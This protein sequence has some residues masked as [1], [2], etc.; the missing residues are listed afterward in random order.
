[1]Y[2]GSLVEVVN[3]SILFKIHFIQILGSLCR[4]VPFVVYVKHLQYV[5]YTC[6]VIFV[7]NFLN[8]IVLQFWCLHL[9]VFFSCIVVIRTKCRDIFEF[10]V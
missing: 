9:S 4:G 3:V 5:Q 10:A 7:G 6:C 1:M 2:C 8:A